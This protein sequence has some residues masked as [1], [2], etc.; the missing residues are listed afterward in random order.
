MTMVKYKYF[1]FA[2]VFD[3]ERGTR[4]KREDHI[5]GETAYV[6]SSARNNGIDAYVSPNEDM[7]VYQNKLTLANSG[8]VGYCFYHPYEFVASDHVMVIWAREKELNENISLFLKPIFEKIKYRYSFGREINKNRLLNESLYLPIDEQENPNWEYM[9]RYITE[10]KDKIKFNNVP[11]VEKEN[12]SLKAVRWEDFTINKLFEVKIGKSI[13]GNKIEQ[14]LGNTPYITRRVTNNGLDNFIDDY[15]EEYLFSNVPVITIG[16]ETAKPFIQLEPF[17]T[18]T[19]VNIMI[20]RINNLKPEVLYF[21][22]VCLEHATKKYTYAY[23]IN[24]TR[25]KKLQIQLPV[26]E[27]GYPN[28]G[29]MEKFIKSLSYSEYLTKVI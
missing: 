21:I 15:P 9:D 29:Y 1:Q 8:S 26:D 11:T 17:Y 23:T 12:L 27:K 2:E 28:W 22:A 5:P 3:Y 6:S 10:L 25:L 7:I 19:K 14:N 18:G 16:N 24:S 4:Y 13:D 20:P